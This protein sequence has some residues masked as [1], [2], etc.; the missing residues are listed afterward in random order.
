MKRT[1]LF[2]ILILISFLAFAQEE[3]KREADLKY[4]DKG[5]RF[6]YGDDYLMN[7]QWRLQFR[8]TLLQGEDP[9][10]FIQEE[11]NFGR[12][13]D[14]Q[15]ARLKVGG[16]AYSKHLKYYIEYDFPSNSLLNWE[17]TYA[18]WS[19]L[20]FKVGQWKVT[21]NTERFVSSGKQQM[22]DRSIANRFF[23]FD[24]QVGA[25]IKG[26]LFKGK[27]I[28]SSYNIGAFN[29][30]GRGGTNNNN[31]I[32]YLLRYQWNFSG[33]VAK[34]SFSDLKRASKPIGFI[35]FAAVRNQSAYTR[36]STAGGGQ[37]PGFDEG[38]KS[39]YLVEQLAVETMLKYKGFSFMAEAHAKRIEDFAIK[40][41]SSLYGGYAM[42]GYFFRELVDFIPD[43][44][45][46]TFRYG[47]ITHRDQYDLDIEEY[48]W[49]VN[50]FFK[51]HRNKLTADVSLLR[52]IDFDDEDDDIRFRIQWDVSF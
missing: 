17:F 10:F 50:Y 8:Y 22:T 47:L 48:S 26:D 30:T 11:D 41:V 34:K 35:G 40:E 51:G 3:N 36:F 6:T 9:D 38:T 31:H 33:I 7:L 32:M 29:G 18:R 27:A 19:A 5:W 49:G 25:S 43:P 2:V 14:L 15:R 21:Y 20:Q 28:C 45:E 42:L 44:L 46:L 37:L 13:F 24:R 23:T 16:H 52:N 39:Q 1:S 4:G 12:S